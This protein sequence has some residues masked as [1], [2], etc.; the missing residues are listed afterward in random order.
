MFLLG[1]FFCYLAILPTAFEWLIKQSQGLGDIV[2]Q[3]S[4]YIDIILKF[5]IGFGI[6][7]QLP[8]IVFYLLVFEIIPYK[9][10]RNSWRVI[11]IVMLVFSAVIT[12]DASPVT[13]L[14]LFGALVAL[15]ESSLMLSRIVLN[16]KIHQGDGGKGEKIL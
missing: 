1:C 10:L 6:A 15:Y 13:M 5:E 12:P 14:L 16:K 11:Y 2:P 7:F 9:K 4:S 3:M 8:L